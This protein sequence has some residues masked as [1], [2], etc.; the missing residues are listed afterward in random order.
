[1]SSSPSGLARNRQPLTVLQL[2]PELNTGGAE[3]SA[4]E[5]CVALTARG[6]RCF[7]ASQGGRLEPE[8]RA[9]GGTLL[10]FPAKTKLPWALRANARKLVTLVKSHGVDIIHARSRAPAWSGLWAARWANVPFVTTYHG[11]YAERGPAKKLYNSVMARGDITIANS[12]YTR[13]LI[14]SRYASPP[15]R[16]RVV[17]RG[18][19]L[20]AF[21]QAAISDEA[22]SELRAAWGLAPEDRIILQA[23]RLTDWKGQHVVIDAA[24]AFLSQQA[25]IGDRA[26]W[27]VVLAGDA[28]G[29]EAYRQGLIDHATRL[30]IG[31]AVKLVGH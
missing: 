24:A 9:A 23:A 14:L 28:Q 15:E 5:V 31:D 27:V 16:V 25:T 2:I 12:A 3:L 6:D 18:V 20:T 30:G 4:I 1:M 29:R 7:V 10:P 19:D 26:N 22:R 17:H 8:L 11:A 21:D 13:D